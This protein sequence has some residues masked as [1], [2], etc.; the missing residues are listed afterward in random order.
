MTS[1]KNVSAVYA[2]KETLA[3]TTNCIGWIRFFIDKALYLA[4]KFIQ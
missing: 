2:T 4:A 1:N 3:I